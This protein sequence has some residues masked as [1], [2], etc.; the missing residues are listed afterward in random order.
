MHAQST[1][2]H[3]G[4]DL[5]G[6]LDQYMKQIA[7]QVSNFLYIYLLQLPAMAVYKNEVVL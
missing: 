6:D 3:Q 4:S 5:F 1:Y 7:S 2:F